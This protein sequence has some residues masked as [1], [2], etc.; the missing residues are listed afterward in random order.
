MAARP[1]CRFFLYPDENPPTLGPPKKKKKKRELPNQL[2]GAG[3]LLHQFRTKRDMGKM[4]GPANGDLA[5]GF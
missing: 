4:V 5:R 2:A 1:R 3:L